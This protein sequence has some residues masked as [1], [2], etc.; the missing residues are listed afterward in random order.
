MMIMSAKAHGSCSAVKID[1][2]GSDTEAVLRL[3]RGHQTEATHPP[4]GSLET[5]EYAECCVVN[6]C[7]NGPDCGDGPWEAGMKS[8]YTDD[9]SVCTGA[10]CES[11]QDIVNP[12]RAG[13]TLP[14]L[15]ICIAVLAS[16]SGLL[17]LRFRGLGMLNGSRA[18]YSMLHTTVEDGQPAMEQAEA[19]APSSDE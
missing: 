7:L 15:A 16:I 10:D 9:F 11:L 4:D 5:A 13:H 17:V 8:K 12:R 14:T 1:C 2:S 3:Y 6:Q 19:I 18:R